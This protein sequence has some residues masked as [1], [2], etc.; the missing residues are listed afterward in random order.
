MVV[1]AAFVSNAIAGAPAIRLANI[2]TR[3]AV[4]KDSNVL[5]AG[6]ILT[7]AQQKNV[8]IRGLGPS[9][10]VVAHLGDPALELHDLGGALLYYNDN[11]HDSQESGLRATTIPPKNDYESGIVRVL[12]PG[13]YTAVLSGLG[14]TTGV[15]LVELYDLDASTDSK[16]ANISTRGF[17]NKGDD[18]LI[19]GVIILG[20]GTTTVLFRAIGPSLPGVSDALQDPTLELHDG[21][22]S[23]IATNDNWQDSQPSEIQATT[24]PPNDPREAAI[25]RQLSPGAYTAIIRGKKNTTGVALVEAYQLD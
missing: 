22:G 18:V 17:V 15:G 24:I 6:F 9:L 16:L 20:S 14:A 13:S 1:V 19:G 23:I 12:S 8:L 21:Q 2:S 5:I 7:G 10:P 25:L 11:W 4:G 3:L